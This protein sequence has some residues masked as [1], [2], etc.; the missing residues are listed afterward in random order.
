MQAAHRASMQMLMISMILV[1]I[2]YCHG[3]Q[4]QLGVGQ[5]LV[6]TTA[7]SSW[8]GKSFVPASAWPLCWS[9]S[10]VPLALWSRLAVPM[11]LLGLVTLILVL[12]F[13]RGPAQR[14][15]PLPGML[16]S[17]SFQPSE[18]VKLAL[19]LYLADVLVRKEDLIKDFKRGFM[20]RL[21]VIGIVLGLIAIQPDLGTAIA[22]GLSLPR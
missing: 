11:F 18:F 16:S 9:L 21:L 12:I 3:L 17:F 4:F 1:G 19:V 22:I 14:W 7:A 20:P 5:C 2:R 10:R 8:N 6:L 15:L 13:G